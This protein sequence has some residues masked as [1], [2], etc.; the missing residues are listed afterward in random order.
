MTIALLGRPDPTVIRVAKNGIWRRAARWRE[1][2]AFSKG[3]EGIFGCGD[4][5]PFP[6]LQPLDRERPATD[7]GGVP[8]FKF[9]RAQVM[10]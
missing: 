10:V 2:F 1:G 4:W 9:E 3:D 6:E 7:I 8:A 5:Q